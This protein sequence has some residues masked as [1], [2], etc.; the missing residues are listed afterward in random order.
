MN[1]LQ[2][3]ENWTIE[4]IKRYECKDK[5]EIRKYEGQH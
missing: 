2:D 3:N 5:N 4:E 1:E